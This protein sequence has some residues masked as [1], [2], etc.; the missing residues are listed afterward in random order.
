LATDGAEVFADFQPTGND[1]TVARLAFSSDGFG[2][3]GDN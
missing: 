1:E 2:V 3:F